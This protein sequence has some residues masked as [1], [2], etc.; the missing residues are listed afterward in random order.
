MCD[1]YR[2]LTNSIFN[3]SKHIKNIVMPA[4]YCG[5]LL[6]VCSVCAL[7]F[8]IFVLFLYVKR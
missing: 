7:S 5:L 3:N 4:E 8:K 2:L 6:P 1:F